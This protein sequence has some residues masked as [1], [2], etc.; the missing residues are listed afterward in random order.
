MKAI[1]RLYFWWSKID[2]YIENNTRFRK[3]HARPIHTTEGSA[4]AMEVAGTSVD[5]L[6]CRLLRAVQKQTILCNSRR[7]LK[8]V[9][10]VR[11]KRGYCDSVHY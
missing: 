4:N 3:L 7:D 9:R 11:G 6:A 1:A 2:S 10:S 5:A 8:M